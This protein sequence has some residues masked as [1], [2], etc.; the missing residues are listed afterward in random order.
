MNPNRIACLLAAAAALCCAPVQGF[1][2]TAEVPVAVAVPLHSRA[3]T[4]TVEVAGVDLPVPLHRHLRVEHGVAE[5]T[6]TVPAGTGRTFSVRVA[7]GHGLVTHAGAMTRDVGQG[8]EGVSR[9]TLRGRHGMAPVELA[10]GSKDAGALAA[11]E[12]PRH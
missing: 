12:A 9:L 1:T 8:P 4:V 10:V 3:A 6:V 11:R 2:G 5:G 7:D